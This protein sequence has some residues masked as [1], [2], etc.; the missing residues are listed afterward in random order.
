MPTITML[1]NKASI[2]AAELQ[3]ELRNNR[4]Q[5]LAR[6]FVTGAPMQDELFLENRDLLV[7]RGVNWPTL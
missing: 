3:V 2:Q 6:Q 5:E 1:P 7:E 4:V